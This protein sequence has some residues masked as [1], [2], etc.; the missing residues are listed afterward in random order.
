MLTF[1]EEILSRPV[2]EQAPAIIKRLERL[3]DELK[4]ENEE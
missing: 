3:L 4:K 2:G 1:E